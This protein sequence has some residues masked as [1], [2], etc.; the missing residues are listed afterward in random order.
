MDIF[1]LSNILYLTFLD[2]LLALILKD[3]L[4][5]PK[6]SCTCYRR[7]RVENSLHS[8]QILRRFLDRH[9]AQNFL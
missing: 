3:P 4:R 7:P 6:Y 2:A 8:E 9:L 1:L 5:N